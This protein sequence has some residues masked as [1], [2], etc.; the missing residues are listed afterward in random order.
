MNPFGNILVR[1]KYFKYVS[2]SLSQHQEK[3]NK[4]CV[5]TTYTGDIKKKA[6][7]DIFGHYIVVFH[8]GKST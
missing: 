5:D 8:D 6:F 4:S 3:I 1:N 2:V 7:P